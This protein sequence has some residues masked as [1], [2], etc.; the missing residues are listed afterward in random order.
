[1][2]VL[3]GA[4]SHR[5]KTLE[6][7]AHM[8]RMTLP[9]YSPELNPQESVWKEIKPEGFYNKVFETMGAVESQLVSVLRQFEQQ[10]E[11]L[12]KLTAWQWILN[13]LN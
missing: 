6:L 1:V 10:T 13:A 9:P 5:S 3:D 11:R 7:P 8:T 2:V 12:K 4:A